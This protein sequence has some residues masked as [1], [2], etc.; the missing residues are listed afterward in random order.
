MLFLWFML[1]CP[2][3]C[4]PTRWRGKNRRVCGVSPVSSSWTS[5]IETAPTL[6]LAYNIMPT[7]RGFLRCLKRGVSEML[8]ATL[9]LLEEGWGIFQV[10]SM[11]IRLSADPCKRT[12]LPAQEV[13][14][15]RAAMDI[16][17]SS[18][19][20]GREAARASP[21]WAAEGKERE[22]MGKPHHRGIRQMMAG[23]G[24]GS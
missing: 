2:P 9:F 22:H 23:R 12:S 21:A 7:K 19:W 11:Q 6:M 15:E 20:K 17:K 8:K 3:L 1:F 13:C 14:S 18:S 24:V 4:C 5:W 16:V 10:D